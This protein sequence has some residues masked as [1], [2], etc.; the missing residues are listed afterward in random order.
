MEC[1]IAEQAFQY[2]HLRLGIH[3]RVRSGTG[4][5]GTKEGWMAD[6]QTDR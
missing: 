2:L 4:K 6:R 5:E 3:V 1:G